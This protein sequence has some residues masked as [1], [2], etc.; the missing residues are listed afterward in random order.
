MLSLGAGWPNPKLFPFQSAQLKTNDG[1]E[2]TFAGEK[3]RLALQ[4]TTSQGCIY[5]YLRNSLN[6]LLG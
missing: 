2:L 5:I 6:R 3:L 1:V 4:Y